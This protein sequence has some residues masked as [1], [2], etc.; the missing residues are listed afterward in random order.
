ML[1]ISFE[2]PRFII[3][4]FFVL[5]LLL[6]VRLPE[7]LSMLREEA[8]SVWITDKGVTLDSFK[9]V[10]NIIKKVR[11]GVCIENFNKIKNG[12]D[13]NVNGMDYSYSK[14]Y[15]PIKGI[16]KVLAWPNLVKGC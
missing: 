16:V 4:L 5:A 14:K 2:N 10:E 3:S 12:Q 9:E 8:E 11:S 1:L 7:D 13:N 6:A 15:F